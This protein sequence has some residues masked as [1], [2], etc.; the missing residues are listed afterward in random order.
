[1]AEP[2]EALWLHAQTQITIVEL[3]QSSG[4]PEGVLREMVEYGALEPADPR[5][6][7]WRFGA[8]CVARVRAAARLMNDLEL[9]TATLALVLT[10]LA[11]IDELEGEVRHLHAQ[12][13]APRR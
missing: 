4:L 9:E 8:D 5:S 2:E 13:V 12:L 6:G 7:D 10:F 3:A 1:M 11:R